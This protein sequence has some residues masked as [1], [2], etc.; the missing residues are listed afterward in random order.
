MLL[1]EF[2]QHINTKVKTN[3]E[4]L[5]CEVIYATD[6]EGNNYDNVSYGPSLGNFDKTR[7]AFYKF[8]PR[9]EFEEYNSEYEVELKVNAIV[10]N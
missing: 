3:S 1:R 2:L 4:L 6:A 5:E 10:I 9:S 7:S 8:L